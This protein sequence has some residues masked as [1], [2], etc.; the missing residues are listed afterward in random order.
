MRTN[1]GNIPNIPK[2]KSE[3]LISLSDAELKLNE[4]QKEDS[5]WRREEYSS[6][7]QKVSS[8]TEL[9]TKNVPW[10][11][12]NP[13]S[14]MPWQKRTRSRYMR[15]Q[16]QRLRMSIPKPL[17]MNRHARSFP[18]PKQRIT[19]S[20]RWKQYH[21]QRHLPEWE[22]RNWQQHFM[23]RFFDLPNAATRPNMSRRTCKIKNTLVG[24]GH[25][26]PE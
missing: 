10:S 13:E 12:Q 1:F 18:N 23:L 25:M 20:K 6:P 4:K 24:R 19:N 9:S 11:F 15:S 26:A 8:K 14:A 21:T 16:N 3:A 22:K 7:L 17:I 2:A 5:L